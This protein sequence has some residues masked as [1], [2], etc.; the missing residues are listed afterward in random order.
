MQKMFTK[1]EKEEDGGVRE[2]KGGRDRSGGVT[3]LEK[4]DVGVLFTS[5]PHLCAS[6]TCP[7]CLGQWSWTQRGSWQRGLLQGM[8][9]QHTC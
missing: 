9:G 3:Q 2:R 4:I 8:S 5:C 6:P 7:L 1:S